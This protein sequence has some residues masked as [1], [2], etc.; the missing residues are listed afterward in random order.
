MRQKALQTG[1]RELNKLPDWYYGLVEIEPDEFNKLGIKALQLEDQSLEKHPSFAQM[2]RYNNDKPIYQDVAYK[3]LQSNVKC[4]KEVA[5]QLYK[6]INVDS[7]Q[8][9]CMKLLWMQGKDRI[10]SGDSETGLRALALLW[11]FNPDDLWEWIEGNFLGAGPERKNRIEQWIF[12]LEDMHTSRTLQPWP[13]WMP[14][15]GIGQFILDMYKFWPPQLDRTF[16]DKGGHIGKIEHLTNL[17][18]DALTKVSASGSSEGYL[19]LN[20]LL[21]HPELQENYDLFAWHM[22]IWKENQSSFLWKPYKPENIVKILERNHRRI[23]TA[24]DLFDISVEMLEDIRSEVQ[25]GEGDLKRLCWERDGQQAY[26]PGPEELFQILVHNQIKCNPLLNNIVGHREVQVSDLNK[27]DITLQ[28]TLPNSN[29]AKIYLE[30]KRQHNAEV[31]SAIKDQLLEKYLSDPQSS[32]GIYGVAW[33]GPDYAIQKRL[34][35]NIYGVI[36]QTPLDLE[37]CLQHYANTIEPNGNIR[38][39][40][41]DLSLNRGHNN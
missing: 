24:D 9:E 18:N 8:S 25:T 20:N 19:I 37:K 31:V 15:R 36:P 41:F 33:Y 35:N 32:F 2:L 13:D 4:R 5:V 11:R 29:T 10:E 7:E 30:L 14:I 17:R 22:D 21:N 23:E 34:L 12:A 38:V 16:S 39:L 6:T 40:V 1:L 27:P 26:K 3:Y 28:V